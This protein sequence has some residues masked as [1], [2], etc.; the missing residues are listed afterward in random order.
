MGS[1]LRARSQK[2]TAGKTLA[3][4]CW[5]SALLLLSACILVD[6]FTPQWNDGKTDSCTAK[7][8]QALYYTEF[9]RD[10][11]GKEINDLAR[12]FTI[13][14]FH[15]LMLKEAAADKGGRMY[16]FGVVNGIFQRYRLNPAMKKQFEQ[17]YPNAPISLAHDTVEV[18]SLDAEVMQLLTA[19][20]AKSDYWEIEDQSLYN[21]LRNP[22]CIYEDRDLAGEA[23][24]E[25]KAIE[26]QKHKQEEAAKKKAA[27]ANQKANQ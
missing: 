8:A 22:L 24:K 14:K 19:I 12:E 11:E 2:P 23:T 3:V 27:E 15:F 7:M 17:E 4:G 5:L 16:R 21:V 18:K 9:R 25:K 1:E 13:D 6:D 10:P 20:N 26:E